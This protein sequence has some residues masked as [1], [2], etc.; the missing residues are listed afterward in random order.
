MEWL[1]DASYF[2]EQLLK[3]NEVS[4]FYQWCFDSLKA[5]TENITLA[6]F[7]T[8]SNLILEEDLVA[9]YKDE[10]R[11][12]IQLSDAILKMPTVKIYEKLSE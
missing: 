7:F 6:K 5:H 10:A 12:E 3:E 1:P 4:N 9:E 11:F 2:K 8:V